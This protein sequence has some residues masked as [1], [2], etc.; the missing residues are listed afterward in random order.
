L[1]ASSYRGKITAGKD[2]L[3]GKLLQ[4][5]NHCRQRFA[6]RQAPTGK[7]P[8]LVFVGA[9]LL[10]ILRRQWAC[11]LKKCCV[12]ALG[13]PVLMAGT[14]AKLK[15]KL[16]SFI[17]SSALRPARNS[18]LFL[19]ACPSLAARCLSASS[20]SYSALG[21]VKLSRTSL[22]FLVFSMAFSLV[23]RTAFS[24]VF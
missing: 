12:Q 21:M 7:K 23:L 24:A 8:V 5:K 1:Q 16:V 14:A 17:A 11:L 20:T 6:C 2:S 10:A 13:R 18:S 9:S 19:G 4:G 22:G 3:A 15:S